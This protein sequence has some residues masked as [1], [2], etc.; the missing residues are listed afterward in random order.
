M[1]IKKTPE[2]WV[3]RVPRRLC[4]AD[5]AVNA[6]SCGALIE[7]Q[8][9]ASR[10]TV[11]GPWILIANNLP[12][13]PATLFDWACCRPVVKPE[14]YDGP[15]ELCHL[16][17]TLVAFRL[18]QG[19]LENLFDQGYAPL[20]AAIQVSPHGFSGESREVYHNWDGN[21]AGR[22]RIEIQFGLSR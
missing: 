2:L 16:E 7:H 8:I 11:A 19:S 13:D 20:V 18:F 1:Q 5:I 6:A 22:M 3:L 10:L 12:Q 14:K 15:I 4:I 9:A 21:S 17:P